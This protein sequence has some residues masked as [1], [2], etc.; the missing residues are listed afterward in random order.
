MKTSYKSMYYDIR[1]KSITPAEWKKQQEAGTHLAVKSMFNGRV[2]IRTDWTGFD[3]S[4][5]KGQPPQIFETTVIVDNKASV[6]QRY[7]TLD[8]A[9][10]GHRYWTA[11]MR[12]PSTILKALVPGIE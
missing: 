6:M 7:A 4:Y 5:K 9:L 1:G 3:M 12:R 11:L 2:C 8:E 10:E